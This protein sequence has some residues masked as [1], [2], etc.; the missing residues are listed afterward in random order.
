MAGAQATPTGETGRVTRIG[1]DNLDRDPPM[2]M[3]LDRPDADAVPQ[4]IPS[5]MTRARTRA[6]IPT[7]WRD[8]VGAATWSSML[9]V[10]A[11]WV[12]GGGLHDLTGWASALTSVG[13]LTGLVSSDLLLLQVL[14]LARIPMVERVYGQDELVRRHRLVGFWSFWLMA[15]HVVLITVGYAATVAINPFVQLWE[16]TVDYPGMLLAVAGTVALVMVVVT[17]LRRA[18]S[19]LRYESWHLLHL[20]AYLGVGLALPHQLWTGQEFLNSPVATIYWWTLW[21]SAAGSVLVFRVGLPLYRSVRHGLRVES[22][23]RESDDVVSVTVRGRDLDR[24]DP[25]PGQFFSWR[26]LN[27]PGWTRA[28]PYSLS[29]VPADDTM[30][31][32]V[33]ELGDG[34][35]ALAD[36]TPGTRVLIEGPYGRLHAGARTRRKVTLMAAGIGICPMRALLE[37]LPQD[38]GDVT[39]LYRAR[40]EADLALTKELD[41]LSRQTGARVVYLPGRRIPHRPTWLPEAAAHFS[42]A[43]ALRHL[44]PDVAEH[45][46]FICGSAAWMDAA[47]AAALDCGVP[48]QRIHLERFSW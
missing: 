14:L 26:F 31:I 35:R 13:R 41:D 7:W 11:L 8:A 23:I 19:A 18:R 45:D 34:S 17:S 10:V 3:L 15:A 37:G 33:K 30:R 44:V 20:Y 27:G 39:L 2:T 21:A 46:V 16:L 40:S 5:R 12:A 28:H 47:R 32:T 6:Q 4:P 38:P 24:L 36:L 22:V 9:V 29:A 25:L 48:A 43:E 1:A 42:D